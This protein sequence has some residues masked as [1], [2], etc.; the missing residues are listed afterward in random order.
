MTGTRDEAHG[1]AAVDP[2]DRGWVLRFQR[3][4]PQP[5]EQVW[6]VLTEQETLA[7]WMPCE[8]DVAGGEQPWQRGTRVTEEGRI[9]QWTWG[10]DVLRWELDDEPGDAEHGMLG[11]T[12]LRLTAWVTE[13]A[14][15]AVGIAGGL[16]VSLDALAE[17]L[18][19]GG[20]S[21]PADGEDGS[22][23]LEHHYRPMFG[24]G[25]VSG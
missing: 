14:E 8:D 13:P 3:T 10:E 11:G 24:L 16:H 17:M 6:G 21:A 12:S 5:R 20:V 15:I 4:L 25:G 2:T 7:R 9:V 1:L 22:T 18:A 23:E 19:T